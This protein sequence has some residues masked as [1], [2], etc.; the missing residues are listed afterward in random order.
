MATRKYS[1]AVNGERNYQDAIAAIGEGEA[2]VLFHEADNPYDERAIAV[3]CHGDT[4]GYLPRD[5]WLTEVLLDEGK[6]CSARVSRLT[7][8]PKNLTGVTLEVQLGGTPIKE[9][10]FDPD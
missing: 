1:V 5:C 3:S 4:I 7:R 9:R 2:V 10:A 6:G 8:G